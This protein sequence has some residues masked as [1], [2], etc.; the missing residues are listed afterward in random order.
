MREEMGK[1]RETFDLSLDGRQI[2]SI[3]VGALVIL[4]VV[5]VLGLN[6]GRQMALR[7]AEAEGGADALAALDRAPAPPAEPVREDSLTFH[8]RLTRER[9][10]PPAEPREE[11]KQEP[12]PAPPEPAPV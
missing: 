4:G 7:Q 3:A 8:D 11:G 5:F 12:A 9:P 2:A 10:A 1:R 6:V